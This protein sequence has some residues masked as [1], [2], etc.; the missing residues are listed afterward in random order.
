MSILF[1][2]GALASILSV[3][4]PAKPVWFP[5]SADVPNLDPDGTFLEMQ[6]AIS[7]EGGIIHCTSPVANE[8]N[9]WACAQATEKM[10]FKPATDV[11]GNPAFGRFEMGMRMKG[12]HGNLPPNPNNL[13]TWVLSIEELPST[14]RFSAMATI[15]LLV[16]DNGLVE[17]CLMKALEPVVPR[18]TAFRLEEEACRELRQNYKPLAVTD[19][20]GKSVPY[21]QRIVFQF[22]R[23][24]P[25]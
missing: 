25:S 17:Q 9:E 20:S 13:Q 23:S 12:R 6:M 3:P 8:A 1:S 21:V 14:V 22:K 2:A 18:E 11:D 5:N 16:S 4:M 10:R 7:P 15:A 24:D 19:S